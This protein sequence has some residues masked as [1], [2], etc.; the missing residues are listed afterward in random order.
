[1][2]E[3]R[4]KEASHGTLCDRSRWKGI[5]DL[6]ADQRRTDRGRAAVSD[7]CAARVSGGPPQSRVVVETCGEAFGITDAALVAGHEVRV[8]PSTLARSLGVGA[9]HLKTDSRDARALSEVS[10]RIDL[11]SVHVPSREAR[12]PG[13]VFARACCPFRSI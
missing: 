1:M 6:R 3:A 4:T 11:P 13:E 7:R 12:R 9:R 8:V 10:F 2:L 5:S